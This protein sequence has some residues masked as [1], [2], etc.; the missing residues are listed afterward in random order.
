MTGSVLLNAKYPILS[1]K[2]K[3]THLLP[4]HT[5]TYYSNM[6][7]YGGGTILYGL[8]KQHSLLILLSIYYRRGQCAR[9]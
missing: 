3:R 9:V 8:Y 5:T 2:E 1:Q 7:T 4:F 6:V